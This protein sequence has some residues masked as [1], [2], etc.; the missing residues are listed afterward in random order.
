MEDQTERQGRDKS[1]WELG[2]SREI[3]QGKRAVLRIEE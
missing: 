1:G 3:K 2:N